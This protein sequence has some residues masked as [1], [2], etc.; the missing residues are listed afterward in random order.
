MRGLKA[1]GKLGHK[2][3]LGQLQGV[4]DRRLR[5]VRAAEDEILA[6]A[7]REQ[8]GLFEHDCDLSAKRLESHVPHV[9]PV[10]GNPAGTDVVQTT[11]KARQGALA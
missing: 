2:S 9:Q 6:N 1:P 3:G 7:H 10:E 8:D 5:G 11:R 4:C